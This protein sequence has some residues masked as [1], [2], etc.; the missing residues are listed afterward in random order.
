MEK[1]EK[2]IGEIT[3]DEDDIL[4][5]DTGNKRKLEAVYGITTLEER[6][7]EYLSKYSIVC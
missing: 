7:L 3:D 1:K 6:H 5:L 2:E 4:L